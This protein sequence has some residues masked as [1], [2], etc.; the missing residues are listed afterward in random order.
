MPFKGEPPGGIGFI[1]QADD[2]PMLMGWDGPVARI[3]LEMLYR[4]T[5]EWMLK[6]SLS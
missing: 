6:A 2:S 5:D 3:D 4:C 1:C